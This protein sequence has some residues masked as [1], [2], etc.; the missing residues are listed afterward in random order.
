MEVEHAPG[1]IAQLIDA[2]DIVTVGVIHHGFVAVFLLQLVRLVDALGAAFDQVLHSGRIFNNRQRLVVP[3]AQHIIHGIAA[4]QL[5]VDGSSGRHIR[6]DSI[7]DGP[8]CLA[9][10]CLQKE[11]LI[12]AFIP[13]MLY[14]ENG[15]AQLLGIDCTQFRCDLHF[16][17]LNRRLGHGRSNGSRLC[18]GLHV[19]R[20]IRRNLHQDTDFTHQK[21]QLLQH[22]QRLIHRERSLMHCH[23]AHLADVVDGIEQNLVIHILNKAV[24]RGHFEHGFAADIVNGRAVKEL[25]HI[26]HRFARRGDADIGLIERKLLRLAAVGVQLRKVGR[27]F[28]VIEVHGDG[29]FVYFI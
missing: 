20:I 1:R 10:R 28:H 3:A 7:N 15:I 26:L 2:I 5:A 19:F 12:L 16:D 23:I 25:H 27:V 24:I 9:Q 11:F 22:L 13:A 17:L 6:V 18:G 4:V 8:A 21:M 29:S 14:V